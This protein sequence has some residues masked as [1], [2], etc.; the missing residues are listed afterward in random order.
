MEPEVRSYLFFAHASANTTDVL[1]KRGNQ[2]PS[3]P[4]HAPWEGTGA[5]LAMQIITQAMECYNH[6][7]TFQSAGVSDSSGP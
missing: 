7:A 1:E 3:F 5:V 2:S 4:Q 6:M